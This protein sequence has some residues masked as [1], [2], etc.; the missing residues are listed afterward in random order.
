MIVC[1]VLKNVAQLF[2]VAHLLLAC[3]VGL[4]LQRFDQVVRRL[5]NGVA[6][7]DAGRRRVLVFEDDSVRHSLRPCAFD[8]HVECSVMVV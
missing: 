6:M 7:G 1:K 8:P 4:S 5:A 3:F 2:E